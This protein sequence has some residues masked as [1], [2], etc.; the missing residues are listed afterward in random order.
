VG[1][2]IILDHE[3]AAAPQATRGIEALSGLPCSNASQRRG[4]ALHSPVRAMRHSRNG[5]A[6]AKVRKSA[7][8]SVKET[9]NDPKHREPNGANG[10]DRNGDDRHCVEVRFLTNIH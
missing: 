3:T 2:A 4:T 9:N 1:L 8:A 10:V 6:D 7:G 5:C